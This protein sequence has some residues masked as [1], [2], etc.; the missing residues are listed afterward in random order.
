MSSSKPAKVELGCWVR[1]HDPD[2]G[3]EVVHLVDEN[4]AQP[5]KNKFPPDNPF[6][7]ALLGSKP[8]DMVS[9]TG[10]TGDTEELKILDVGW[11]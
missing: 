4:Q 6:A 10:V 7:Q 3:E 2:L 8:G 1:L 9:F 5:T 11:D